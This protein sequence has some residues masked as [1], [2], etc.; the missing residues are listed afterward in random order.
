MWDKVDIILERL[1]HY[2]IL[3]LILSIVVIIGITIYLV[4]FNPELV[5][6]LAHN[7]FILASKGW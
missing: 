6:K 4:L 3:L 2:S 5:A 1:V 7:W